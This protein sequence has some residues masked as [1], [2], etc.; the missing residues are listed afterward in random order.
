MLAKALAK[1]VADNG[2]KVIVYDP[3]KT[4]DW[5]ATAL[6]YSK[7]D[8]FLKDVW[9]HENVHVF[10]DESKTL[11]QHDVKEAEKLAYLGRHGGRLI[12]F[13][14]QRA[15]SMIPPNARNQCSK[16]FAFKQSLKDSQTLADEYSDVFLRCPKLPK[17]TFVASDGFN[18]YTG[19]LEFTEKTGGIPAINLKGT[20][21]V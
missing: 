9:G 11:F 14:G 3:L 19:V 18:D 20:E 7:P 2:Q 13:I 21:N 12:Y 17:I 8:R 16:I 15:L 6:L 4:G 1:K 5:P 10:V